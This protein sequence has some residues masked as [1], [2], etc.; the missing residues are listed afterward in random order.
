MEAKMM[1][2][3]DSQSRFAI[4]AVDDDLVL[5]KL[6]SR[7]FHDRPWDV[8]ICASAERAAELTTSSWYDL[9]LLDL[10]M[11]DMDGYA[12]ARLMRKREASGGPR[13]KIVALT[14][15]TS[16]A[17]RANALEAGCDGF[18]TKPFHRAQLADAIA[19]YLETP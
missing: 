12:L 19:R 11:P 3:S 6:L 13:V 18:L 8:T 7:T 10:E 2:L 14:A 1:D 4:L 9:V 16:V 15:Q 17:H 5:L